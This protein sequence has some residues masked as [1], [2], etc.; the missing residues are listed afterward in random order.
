MVIVLRVR[1]TDL[2]K[3]PLPAYY[4]DY[5]VALSLQYFLHEA[6]AETNKIVLENEASYR[7]GTCEVS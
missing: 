2:G 6:K 7:N 1:N 4:T 5:T 3:L